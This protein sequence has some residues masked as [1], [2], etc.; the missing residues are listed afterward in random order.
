[1]A[2]ERSAVLSANPLF[3]R[4]IQA[5]STKVSTGCIIKRAACRDQKSRIAL[6]KCIFNYA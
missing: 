6:R 3:L 1:M 2:G 5:L 4:R